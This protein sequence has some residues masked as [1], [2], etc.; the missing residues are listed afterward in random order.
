[1]QPTSDTPFK[2]RSKAQFNNKIIGLVLAAG[3]GSRF[4]G[5]KLLH[6]LKKNGL[7]IGLQSAINI[8]PYVDEVLCI[9]RPD[10]HGLKALFQENGFSII[11]NYQHLEGLSSSIVTG[12]KHSKRSD[13]WLI[14]LADMPFISKEVYAELHQSI[15]QEL[16]NVHSQQRILRPRIKQLAQDGEHHFSAGHPVAFPARYGDYLISLNGDQGAFRILKQA[17]PSDIQYLDTQCY[18]ILRDIDKRQDLEQL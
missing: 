8:Q 17:S 10:D 11:E 13:Y 4:G 9:V 2:A 18:G 16:D 1:M 14:A 3:Q 5:D 12:V 7:E 15:Q 6:P